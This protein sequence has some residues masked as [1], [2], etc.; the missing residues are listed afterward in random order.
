VILQK[1]KNTWQ[2]RKHPPLLG[3][4]FLKSQAKHVILLVLQKKKKKKMKRM[5]KPTF[6]RLRF[7]NDMG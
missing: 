3:L 5:K 4:D 1:K 2:R 7:F 6:A